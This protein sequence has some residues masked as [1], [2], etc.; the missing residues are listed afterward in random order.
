MGE[1]GKHIAEELDARGNKVFVIDRNK[2]KID[3]LSDRFSDTYIGDCTKSGF[4]KELGVSTFDL[5]IVA[6]GE[7]F[8]SSLETTAQLKELG[9][10]YI[11]AKAS[12]DIQCKFLKMAGANE[13]IYA[14]RDL[15]AKLAVKYDADNV[16][17][18][19]E[20]GDSHCIYEFGVKKWTGKTLQELDVRN[21]YH[22]NIVAIKTEDGT[23]LVPTAQ[24]RF[25]ADD[26]AIVFG[27]NKDVEKLAKKI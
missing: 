1:F 14:Q 13:T 18:F 24:Y 8:Q 22:I 12:S 10:K 5:C 27:E 19:I 9:A 25:A 6:I 3:E 23:T 26:H 4:L 7:D 2:S 15:A 21:K 17:D 20:L 16:F 11:V